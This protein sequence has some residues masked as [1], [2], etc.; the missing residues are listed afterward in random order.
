MQNLINESPTLSPRLMW[1][2]EIEH[3]HEVYYL[4][5]EKMRALSDLYS[6]VGEG[7]D[8]AEAIKDFVE[9]NGLMSFEQWRIN[10]NK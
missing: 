10:N 8:M 7:R 4:E 3:D 2:A 6:H 1:E 5:E 9:V